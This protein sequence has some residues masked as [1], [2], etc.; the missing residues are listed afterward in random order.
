MGKRREKI[1]Q[2]YN[3]KKY[4]RGQNKEICIYVKEEEKKNLVFLLGRNKSTIL[5]RKAAS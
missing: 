1:R 2:R 5:L 4:I 3:K